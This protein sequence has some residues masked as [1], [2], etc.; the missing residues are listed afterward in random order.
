MNF[1]FDQSVLIELMEI[2]NYR[3]FMLK[4]IEERSK[5][6]RFGYSDIARHGGFATRSFP[7]DVVVG[8]KRLTLVSLPK[9]VRGL[10]LSGDL[11]DYFKVLVEIEELDCRTKHY[12]ESKLFQIKE[13]LKRRI[14]SRA[15]IAVGQTDKAFVMSFIPKVYAG[16]GGLNE[17]SDIR[18]I[19]EKTLLSE[20]E[21]F[22]A[23]ECML[24]NDLAYKKGRKYFAKELHANFQGLKSEIFKNHFIKTAEASAQ[25]SR[26]HIG[27]E[28]KLF[29][30]SAVS[31]SKRDL[32]KLKEEL[33]SVLLRFVDNSENSKGDTVVNLVASLY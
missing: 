20:A 28:D 22:R 3:D 6:K 12:D 30:S 18:E 2:S 7:R 17:G 8:S 29:L 26:K 32:P 10:G 33:R 25:M 23:L 13:N 27:S 21:V 14:L 5:I 16:L 9:I 1:K 24:A 31:V 19:V 11:A 15:Q 4:L